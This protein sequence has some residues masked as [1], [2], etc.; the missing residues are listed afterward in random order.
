VTPSL[1]SMFAPRSPSELTHRFVDS[2]HDNDDDDAAS[3]TTVLPQY[4]VIDSQ[5][6]RPPS[7]TPTYESARPP[8]P[9]PTYA[10]LDHEDPLAVQARVSGGRALMRALRSGDIK[11]AKTLLERNVIH[12]SKTETAQLYC[13]SLSGRGNY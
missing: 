1:V 6:R 5:S 12:R 8:S 10:T 3:I 13:I 9:A 4:S 11:R 2:T 7:P